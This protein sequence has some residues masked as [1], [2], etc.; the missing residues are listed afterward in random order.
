MNAALLPVRY[1][2]TLAYHDV[3]ERTSD[4]ARPSPDVNAVLREIKVSPSVTQTGQNSGQEV[5]DHN[6]GTH[7]A[8]HHQGHERQTPERNVAGFPSQG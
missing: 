6:H 8:T 7:Y 3:N 5:A 2:G 1:H 4:G